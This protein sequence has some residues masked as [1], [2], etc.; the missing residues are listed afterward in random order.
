MSFLNLKT[1]AHQR[2]LGAWADRTPLSLDNAPFDRPLDSAWVRFTIIGGTEDPTE[3]GRE[4]YEMQGLF[5][6][7]IFTPPGSGSGEAEDLADQ[8]AAVFRGADFGG[9]YCAGAIRSRVGTDAESG[10]HQLNVSIP[11][12]YDVNY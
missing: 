9:I 12:S 5:E 3:L 11:F 2:L 6:F 8:A 1:Q 7:Q 4:A 10:M